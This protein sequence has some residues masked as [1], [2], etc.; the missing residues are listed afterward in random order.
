MSNLVLIHRYVDFRHD[1]I[2]QIGDISDFLH[3]E[4]G[5]RL[6]PISGLLSAR[7]FL[8][9]LAFRVFFSTQCVPAYRPVFSL[10]AVCIEV[11]PASWKSVLHPRTRHLP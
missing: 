8:N 7:D 3:Q 10:T 4:T 11:H 2:P 5:F 9:A 1:K 6:R